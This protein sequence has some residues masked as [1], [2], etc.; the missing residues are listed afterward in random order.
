MPLVL[1]RMLALAVALLAALQIAVAEDA[2]SPKVRAELIA[3]LAAIRPGEPFRVGLHQKITPNWHT[4]WK[5]PGD[6]GEPTRLTWKLPQGFE[7]S[8]ID[9]PAPHALPVGPLMNFGYSDAILLPLTITPPPDFTGDTVRLEALAEWLVCEKICIPEQQEVSLELKVEHGSGTPAPSAHATLFDS[10]TREIPTQSPW[11]SS[12]RGD[13]GTLILSISGSGL[14]PDRIANVRF[15]PDTWGAVEH[16]AP[17]ELSW[18]TEG[19]SLALKPGELGPGNPP[20]LSGVVVLTERLGAREV[21]NAFTLTAVHAGNGSAADSATTGE[22]AGGL[23]VGL[24]LWQAMLFATL[25]GMILNLMPCVLPILSLKVF[26]LVREGRPGGSEARVGALAYFAGVLV[27]FAVF[28]LLLLALRAAGETLGWGFQFQSPVFVLVMTGMFFALGLSMSGVFDIGGSIVGVGSSLGRQEGHAGSFFTGVLAAIAA[29]PCTAPFMGAALGYALTQPAVDLF[30][31]LLALGIGF[32]L[33][34]V[35]LAVTGAA[36]SILPKPG[37]WM[38]TLKQVLAFPL[39]AT[40][41]W[42]VW[43]LS[44]QSG[45]SGVL[46]AGAVLMAVGFG[47][48]LLGRSAGSVPVRGSVG[49][50]LVAAAFV[51]ALQV[52]QPASGASK[53][54]AASDVPAYS[55]ERVAELRAQGRPVFVNFTAAWCISCKVNERVALSGAGFHQALASHNVAYLKA[56]WTNKDERIARVL[57]SYGRAG[58]PLYLLFPSDLAKSAIVL[59]ELLTEAIVVRHIASLSRTASGPK[60]AGD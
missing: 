18:T 45:S 34:V 38:E 32:A 11:R 31:V 51:F 25:G 19:L 3:P 16:A 2:S 46:A 7:A 52:L 20:R 26:A 28:A 9:W 44:V 5:N 23:N 58:V 24:A 14:E 48:W 47:A 27:S 30:A 57:K 17:Q 49:M 35:V 21:R 12:V 42:L 22:E 59:P 1:Q 15:F 50:V 55:S 39:Y 40:V 56:D 37:P 33:P 53:Q 54:I 36:R 6:S 43:V 13:A 4:Y 29:T 8:E 41:V 60:P 10:A